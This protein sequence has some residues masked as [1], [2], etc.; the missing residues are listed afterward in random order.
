M[1]A[2]AKAPLVRA[3]AEGAR[4]WL[5]DI[6]KMLAC[7]VI[8]SWLLPAAVLLAAGSWVTLPFGHFPATCIHPD[9]YQDLSI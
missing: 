5:A 7:W 3:R 6:I 4:D 9:T 1:T 8:L 2:G